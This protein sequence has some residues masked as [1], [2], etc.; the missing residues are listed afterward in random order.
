MPILTAQERLGSVIAGRYRVQRVLANGGMS[1]LFEARDERARRDVALKLLRAEDCIEDRKRARFLQEMRL[2]AELRHPHVV[3]VLDLGEDKD[4]APFLVMELMHGHSLQA[5][6]DERVSLG[7]EQA[8]SLTLPVMEALAAV[9]AAGVVHRDVKPDNIFLQLDA[10]K[11]ITPKLLDFGIAKTAEASLNTRTGAVLGTPHYMAPEQLLAAVVGPGADIWAIGA[12]LFRM[13]SG[14]VPFYAASSGEVIAKLAR[15]PAPALRVPGLAPAICTAIDRALMRD[16]ADRYPSMQEF[17]T[18]LV[19]CARENGF[20]AV[21]EPA[22][23]PAAL[24]SRHTLNRTLTAPSQSVGRPRG[25][26][27]PWLALAAGGALIVALAAW[28]SVAEPASAPQPA[29]IAPMAIEPA[30]PPLPAPTVLAAGP[31]AEP[32]PPAPSVDSTRAATGVSAPQATSARRPPHKPRPLPSA[33][34]PEPVR[35]ND[36]AARFVPSREPGDLPV[37]V[38]W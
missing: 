17:A 5:E 6:L 18:A 9:H 26:F 14:R 34:S 10:R 35:P 3:D 21:H 23:P 28:R 32:T 33:R 1:V 12:V 2:T 7:F 25:R 38:Q 8:L 37:A 4:G 27:A 15:D 24:S 19:L 31:G 13:L 36:S 16:P 22:L 29:P 11:S 20:A 30:A